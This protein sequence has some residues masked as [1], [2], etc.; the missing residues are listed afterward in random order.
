M[1]ELA[2]N[3]PMTYWPTVSMLPEIVDHRAADTCC[4]I[5]SL[6][7]SIREAARFRATSEG[8]CTGR[9]Y[10]LSCVCCLCGALDHM[11]V[12]S[13]CH[14]TAKISRALWAIMLLR[15]LIRRDTILTPTAN[16]STLER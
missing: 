14:D 11:V 3:P 6:A 7:S 10:A 15:A 12:F 5:A 8:T 9:L 16:R 2:S 4:N 13:N 1:N